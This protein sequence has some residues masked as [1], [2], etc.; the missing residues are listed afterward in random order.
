VKKI[1]QIINQIKNI[2]EKIYQEFKNLIKLQE[3]LKE[4]LYLLKQHF[5]VMTDI[6][7]IMDT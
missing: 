7:I 1:S 3:E 4:N 5:Q 6:L 2:I